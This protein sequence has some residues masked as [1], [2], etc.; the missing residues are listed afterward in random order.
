LKVQ[1][2]KRKYNPVLF[3]IFLVLGAFLIGVIIFNTLILPR[4]V[5]RRDVVI[6]PELKAM[7]VM[8]AEKKCRDS[9]LELVVIGHRNST[10]IPEGYI[11]EQDPGPKDGLKE[12]RA[13]RVIVSSGP[14]METIPEL[15]NKSL[16]QAEL[17]LESSKL[18][19]GRVVRIFSHEE[20]QNSV[21]STSP[22]TGTSV[23]CNSSVDILLTVRG[24]PRKFLMPDLVGMDLPFVKDRLG[25]LGFHVTRVVNRRVEGKFPNTI[26]SQNPRAGFSIKEGGTIELVVSTV[27]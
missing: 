18:R 15:V 8:L 24:E 6:V 9:G 1:A 16:R 2:E 13:I 11:I 26:L 19:R 17:L 4:L 21:L 10:E 5:G 3:Y 14:R 12:G 22:P 27:E 25:R 7:S 23:P 20:G